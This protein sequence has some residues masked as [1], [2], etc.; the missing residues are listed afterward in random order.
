MKE[1]KR[2]RR[3]EKKEKKKKREHRL[4]NKS[5]LE[6]GYHAKLFRVPLVF[7]FSLL[8]FFSGSF[9]FLKL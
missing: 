1:K 4:P 3:E 5:L 2:E 9:Y 7:L 6:P 8:L